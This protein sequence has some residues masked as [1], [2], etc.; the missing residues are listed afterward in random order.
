V[1]EVAFWLCVS[2]CGLSY[3]LY[4][5][6]LRL[7]P[8]RAIQL[9]PQAELPRVS[10][11]ITARNEQ[12][13]IEQKLRNTLALDYPRERL[14]IIVASDASD[15]RTD[16]IARSLSGSG[17][18]LSRAAIRGGKEAAQAHAIAGSS[19]EIIVFT[20]TT[21]RLDPDAIR[22]I[23][24]NFSDPAV[25]AVSSE[26][27]IE[28]TG[29]D[30]PSSGEGA[31]VRYEMW[32]RRLESERAGLV[33]LSGSLF[34]VRRIVAEKWP[35]HVPSD[36]SAAL[37]TASLGLRAI[38]DP[39][40]FGYYSDIRD[41]SKE[42]GRKVRTVIRGMAAIANMRHLLNPWR[43]GWYAIQLWGHKIFRWLTPVFL[44]LLVVISAALAFHHTFYMLA[45]ALQAVLYLGAAMASLE[46]RLQGLTFFRL[47]YYFT[48]VHLA[49]LEA[50]L[51]FLR[52]ER[53]V[54]WNPS[55]R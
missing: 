53:V 27:R 37:R 24:T 20:D 9:A 55:V 3:F 33:G 39:E 22:R 35:A 40:L 41:A 54:V 32:L 10:I 15:D 19:G 48:Q 29:P 7:A 46:P 25:G 43:Y 51:R 52:N 16:E 47:T 18:T 6:L 11:I 1:L 4:P 45:F 21:T 36:I 5:G 26:D 17:V 44:A 12:K 28:S 49:L 30:T 50:G 34:A 13:R 8:R 38:S 31:Y 42:Y 23:V 2:G 14:E